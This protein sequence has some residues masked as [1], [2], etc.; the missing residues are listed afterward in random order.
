MAI[1]HTTKQKIREILDAWTFEPERSAKSLAAEYAERWGVKT[2]RAMQIVSTARQVTQEL[3]TK[4][5]PPQPPGRKSKKE[6]KEAEFDVLPPSQW[7][8]PEQ[9]IASDFAVAAPGMNLPISPQVLPSTEEELEAFAK[10]EVCTPAEKAQYILHI[11]NNF[12]S[13]SGTAL[14]YMAQLYN[15]IVQKYEDHKGKPEDILID[16][17]S[18]ADTE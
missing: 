5:A 2:R 1:K 18:T 15:E 6:V 8:T 11:K 4:K 12:Y 13:S 10:L 3:D 7:Q 16:M 17:V 14:K 9:K